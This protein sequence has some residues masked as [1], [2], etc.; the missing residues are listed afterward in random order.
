MNHG[1]FL[2]LDDN[3]L[4]SELFYFPD[5]KT[6]ISHQCKRQG[7]FSNAIFDQCVYLGG[8]KTGLWASFGLG[9]RDSFKIIHHNEFLF[10]RPFED[11][12]GEYNRA[13]YG[14]ISVLF[15]HQILAVSI[16]IV[17][18]K[19]PGQTDIPLATEIF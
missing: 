2:A 19:V 8:C 13:L 9:K 7:F 6:S 12:L 10:P 3:I 18:R 15:I 17:F 1:V 16:E 4:P 5:P 14:F 11:L